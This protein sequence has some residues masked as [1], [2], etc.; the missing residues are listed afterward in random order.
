[1]GMLLIEIYPWKACPA[2]WVSTST[3]A[4][5]PLKFE[6]MKGALYEGKYP[7]P[8]LYCLL[9]PSLSKLNI[10]CSADLVFYIPNGFPVPDKIKM[11]HDFDLPAPFI[12][13]YFISTLT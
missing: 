6:N 13:E 4:R 11:I 1:M 7:F 3:S 5:V 10:C 9:M 12:I 2:S 8:C